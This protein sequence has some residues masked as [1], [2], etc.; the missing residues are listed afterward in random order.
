MRHTLSLALP[1]AVAA[2][3]IAGPALAHPGHDAAGFLGGLEHPLSGADHM[4]AMVAVGLWASLKGGKVLVAW[5][6]A[7]VAAM[8]AGY[9]L[10]LALP[11]ASLVEPAILASV[12]VLGGLVAANVRTPFLAGVG[13]IALFGLAH[14]YAHGAEAP[15]GGFTFPLGFALAT[16]GLHLAGLGVG[17]GLLKLNRPALVRAL[18]A[19][20]AVGGLL[21]AA[22]A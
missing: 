10:G 13:L 19:G 3:L 15:A 1:A 21:L 4:L 14:G 12:I 22:A 11:G 18:G 17:V 16:L 7:F 20:T 2:T 6:A 5:P 8:L 9:G